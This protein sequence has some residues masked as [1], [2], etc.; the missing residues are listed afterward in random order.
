[1]HWIQIRCLEW[2][3]D[4]C[5]KEE[6]N[7]E[8]KNWRNFP[9]SWSLE[10]THVNVAGKPMNVARRS[11]S[12]NYFLCLPLARCS[13]MSRKEK[14]RFSVASVRFCKNRTMETHILND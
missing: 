1:M 11:Y 2:N 7:S 13:T 9:Q 12:N 6:E 4:D 3:L 5:R 10:R 8:Q 14:I